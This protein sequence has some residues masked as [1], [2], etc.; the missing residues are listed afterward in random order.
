MW[1]MPDINGGVILSVCEVFFADTCLRFGIETAFLLDLKVL[2][3][4]CVLY[5]IFLFNF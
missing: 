2:Y 4:Q 1:S 5:V 3:R